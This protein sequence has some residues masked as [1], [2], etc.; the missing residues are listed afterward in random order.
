MQTANTGNAYG[1]LL[2]GTAVWLW[3]ALLSAELEDGIGRIG[4]CFGTENW[5]Q[6]VKNWNW[7]G[8]TETIEKVMKE[9]NVC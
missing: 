4:H 2:P 1:L 6:I 9:E 7:I 3:Y 8:E 5:I